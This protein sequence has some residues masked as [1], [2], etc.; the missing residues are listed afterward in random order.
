M[1]SPRAPHMGTAVAAWAVLPSRVRSKHD[2]ENT[3]RTALMRD[4]LAFSSLRQRMARKLE[5]LADE[6]FG[7]RWRA[8][9]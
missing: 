5:W 9:V 8:G 4:A 7:M 3:V 6:R 1:V 2:N